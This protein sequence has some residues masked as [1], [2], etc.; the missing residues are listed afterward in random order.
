MRMNIAT[1]AL[2]IAS[3]ALLSLSACKRNDAKPAAEEDTGYGSEHALFEKTF[4]D[5]E[6]ITEQANTGSLSTYKMAGGRPTVLGNCATITNDTSVTPYRLTIDFGTTNCQSADGKYRRGQIIVVYTGRYRDPGHTHTISFNN[7]FVNDHQVLGSKTVTH[8]GNTNAGGPIYSINVNG[9][10]Q[11][12]NSGGT[13][14]WTGSRTRTWMAGYDTQVWSDDV[15]QVTGSGTFTRANGD[16]YQLSITKPLDIALACQWIR[17]G[18]IQL[19]V[20]NTAYSTPVRTVDYGN[21]S[22]DDQAT[23]TGARGTRTFTL[24]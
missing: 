14:S 22:C 4:S 2:A 1:T 15:Y 23:V 3:L 13:I 18:T 6:S 8:T 16:Q 24:R 17:S 19:M 12:A 7:Y 11:L 21:G 20:A 5:V 10:I 9:Q